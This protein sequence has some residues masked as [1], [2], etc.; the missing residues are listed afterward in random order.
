MDWLRLII[1]SHSQYIEP[2]GELL[3]NFGALSLSYLPVTDESLFADNDNGS[4]YWQKTSVV[5]LLDKNIDLDILLACI[6]NRIGTEQILNHRI[7]A[8]TDRHW[9][10]NHKDEHGT[11]VYGNKLCIC[12]SWCTEPDNIPFVIRLD[13][14]LAFGTGSHQ[15]TAL[16]LEWLA[17]ADLNQK[18]IIDYGCGS[19]V[20]ALAAASLGAA[21]VDA[22]D[23]D[24]QALTAT[25]MNVEK[26]RFTSIIK[27][28]TDE[29]ALKAEC[30]DVLVANIL[31]NPLLELVKVFASLVK[32]GGRLV[33]SGLL[34]VQTAECLA[35]Y[36]P[37]FM[38]NGPVFRDEWAMLH[39]VRKIDD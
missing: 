3:E 4:P 30:A 10:D 9:I 34:S 39:G 31:L 18:H 36:S 19:G 23:V 11:L 5:A 37:W 8:V 15:T 32:P 38:M 24:P 22:V 7:E 35:A 20:L 2:L 17:A 27:T 16:C 6:R 26:N 33:I 13:P 25:R 1:T 29:S 12:P 14:G 28:C 21:V